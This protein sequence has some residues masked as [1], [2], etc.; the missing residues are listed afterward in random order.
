MIGFDVN[1]NGRRVCLAGIN[2]PCVMTTVLDWVERRPGDPDGKLPEK[3]LE[4]HVGGLDS[5]T[6]EHL[7]WLHEAI[8]VGSEISI[9]VVDVQKVDE[10]AER[11][12]DERTQE[13]RCS[14]CNKQ[15]TQVAKLT[16]GPGANICNE[17]VEVCVEELAP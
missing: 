5:R 6:N 16:K 10:P 12:A 1:L 14:F 15:H 11:R 2:G 13:F 7:K 8:A 3:T 4:L 17:C 9:R